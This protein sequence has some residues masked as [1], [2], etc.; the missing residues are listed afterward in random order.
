MGGSLSA[1]N[2]NL[3]LYDSSRGIYLLDKTLV[4]LQFEIHRPSR[5]ASIR[6]M[7]SSCQSVLAGAAIPM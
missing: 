6:G 4:V 3:E 2:P 5:R 1:F 7:M